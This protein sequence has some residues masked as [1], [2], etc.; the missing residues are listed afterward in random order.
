MDASYKELANVNRTIT[1]LQSETMKLS[2]LLSMLEVYASRDALNVEISNEKL[3]DFT[4][5]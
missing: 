3:D 4:Y 2:A 5:M 1:E